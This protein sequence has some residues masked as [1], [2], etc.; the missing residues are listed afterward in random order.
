MR[1]VRLKT[2]S[3]EIEAHLAKSLLDDAGIN[4]FLSNQNFS[5]LHP[6]YAFILGSG[7]ELFVDESDVAEANSIINSSQATDEKGELVCKNCGSRNI[8]FKYKNITLGKW[9]LL[10]LSL[11]FFIPFG[12]L[13]KDR[14][15]KDC[16]EML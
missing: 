10:F 13:T 2:Y 9:M 1:S 7:V 8:V 4:C 15:C 11:L 5:S 6:N 12:N 14:V 3:S 16:G